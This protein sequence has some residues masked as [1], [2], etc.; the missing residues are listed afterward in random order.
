MYYREKGKC[1]KLSE[2]DIF[3]FQYLKIIFCRYYLNQRWDDNRESLFKYLEQVNTYVYA[4]RR[5]GRGGGTDPRPRVFFIKDLSKKNIF[6]P[7]S[8]HP[9]VSSQPSRLS[10]CA[11]V[12]M[13]FLP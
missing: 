5:T 12:Y 10:M 4:H 2:C 11:S 9:P 7:Y 1:C 6:H 8:P 3:E 13:F